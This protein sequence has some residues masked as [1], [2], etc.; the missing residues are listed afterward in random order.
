M[1][2]AARISTSVVL[3]LAW[4][5]ASVSAQSIR[6][7]VVDQT[8]L[9]LPGVTIHLVVDD[10]VQREMVTDD[11]GTFALGG[12]PANAQV[13]ASLAGFESTRVAAT[14]LQRIVL[15]LAKTSETTDVVAPTIVESSPTALQGSA[16]TTTTVARLPSAHMHAKESLPLLPSVIRG[17][18]GLMQLGGARAYQTPLTLDGFNVTDPATG[19]SSLNLPLEAVLSIEA[20]RDPMAIT[21][22]GLL[23]GLIRLESRTGDLAR[24]IGVQGVIP[25]PRFSTP[26]FGRLEG[27][28]PRGHYAGAS[29]NGQVRFMFAGEYDYERIPVPG[30]TDRNGPDLVESAGILFA[31]VDAHI[32]RRSSTT[33][34]G[35]SFPSGTQS[36]GL[37]PRRDSSATVD[38][39][40][41][42]MFAGVTHRHA[43]DSAGVL[44]LRVG[45]YGRSFDLQPKGHSASAL[46]TSDGWSGNWF[47]NGSRQ[48][49]RVSVGATWERPLTIGQAVHEVSLSGETS[50]LGLTGHLVERPIE[51]Q[52]ADGQLLRRI[53]FGPAVNL[54][55]DDALIGV[56]ARDVW[57][58]NPRLQ[59][60]S[61]VRV[62]RASHESTTPSGR[63][64]IRFVVDESGRTTIKGGLGTFV[65]IVP[66]AT[67]AFGDHPAREDTRFD[68]A[69]GDISRQ[70]RLQPMVGQLEQP[71]ARTAV[72]ALERE[73][74]QGFDL[75]V[76]ASERASSRLA[77]LNVPVGGGDLRVDSLGTG[78]YR[79]FQISVRHAWPHDQLLFLSY[80]RSA[81]VGELNEFSTLFQGM[82]APLL[83]P[84]RVARSSNDAPHRVLAWGTFN[85]PRRVVVSPLTEWHSGF[86]YSVYSQEYAYNGM[87]NTRRFPQ[88]LATDMV[89]Y[90]TFTVRGRTADVGLQVFNLFNHKNPRDVFPVAG[91]PRF[92]EFANSVG[93]IFRGYM[94]LKW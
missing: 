78:R 93:R 35:F 55:S 79:E 49:K 15:Q 42:D 90:K 76:S 57:H 74:T 75:Q 38:L 84:G 36:S 29:A 2:L 26:G 6:I 50:R 22:G 51:M 19:L 85:L 3:L 39:H 30:V 61:G 34:E 11:D 28:F 7:I 17:A 53:S 40:G 14:D 67:L 87:P 25:R 1:S 31:R 16:L 68:A 8:G 43:W 54:Q 73:I 33:F 94:L 69:T 88:F 77:T 89:S 82:D 86:P 81:S 62:D 10:I 48:T 47:V 66:L 21:Y 71:R 18:D 63:V 60:E 91:A 32:T 64:G 65:G 20:L 5:V 27:I 45:V 92:G 23:G 70:V 80:V 59:I 83:E 44:T 72:I 46:L 9:P 52:T 4:L 56:A 58:V 24:S 12:A 37:S 41:H 13:E